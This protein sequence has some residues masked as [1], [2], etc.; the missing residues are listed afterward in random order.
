MSGQHS[1]RKGYRI[2]AKIRDLAQEMGFNCQRVPLS[3]SAPGWAGDLML[4]GRTFEVKAR[5]RGFRRLYRWLE[6]YFGLVLA[7]DRKEPLLVMR[8]GDFLRACRF[9]EPLEKGIAKTSEQ[10]FDTGFDP[11]KKE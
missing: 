9:S 5:G 11:K 1:K 4:A 8:L 10:V 6:G 7:T 3:G 2:E